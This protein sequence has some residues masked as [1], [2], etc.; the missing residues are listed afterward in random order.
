MYPFPIPCDKVGA[1]DGRAS[2]GTVQ[3]SASAGARQHP[4]LQSQATSATTSSTPSAQPS[5]QSDIRQ[6]G[7]QWKNLPVSEGSTKEQAI[8]T[9]TSTLS[10]AG[11]SRDVVQQQ[12]KR[13][14]GGGTQ[15]DAVFLSTNYFRLKVEKGLKLYR[16][17]VKVSPEAKG[18]KLAQMIKDAL[19][20]PEFDAHRPGLVSD[21]A[22]VLLS[23]QKLEDDLLK[24][25]VPYEKNIAIE[26]RSDSISLEITKDSSAAERPSRYYVTFD[27]IRVVDIS[28]DP[29]TYGS[30]ADQGD[31]PVVQDLDIVL[32]HHRKSAPDISMIGKRRAFYMRSPGRQGLLLAAAND[33]G[34][35]NDEALLVAVRGYFSSV[36]LSTNETLVNINVTHGTFYL[37]RQLSVWWSL[38][39]RH[40][41]VHIT[42]IPSLLKGLR[43]ELRYLQ[44]GPVV[45]TISGYAASGQGVGY[46]FHPP[47][48]TALTPGPQHV[49]FFEYKSEKPTM[50]QKDKEAAS[51]GRLASHDRHQCRC[52]GSYVSVSDYFKR[53]MLDLQGFP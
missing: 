36:R 10:Q 25:S 5:A 40:S 1:D 49:E 26:D 45:K 14:G 52:D 41:Q 50:G 44:N 21:F 30:S 24:V 47:I 38:L 12:P 22:A 16:Y 11:S 37:A 3:S 43:V 35:T 8:K 7:Q 4:Q 13:P 31:L 6:T 39:R 19:D 48:V 23:P 42:K 29:S 18:R 27:L 20:L 53:R 2:T 46:E 33:G 51:K 32:G 34:A 17:S 9:R 15:G 28:N